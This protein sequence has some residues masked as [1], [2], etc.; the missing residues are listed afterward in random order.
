MD[1]LIPREK[2]IVDVLTIDRL[3]ADAE[4]TLQV[5]PKQAD[6]RAAADAEL[7][8]SLVCALTATLSV[9]IAE[10]QWNFFDHTDLLDFP[11]ARSRLKLA[12]LEDVAKAKGLAK[13]PNPL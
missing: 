10:K 7:P 4:D 3:G 13:A 9:A 11:G 2:S 8:R 1:A 5:R 6:G 12:N